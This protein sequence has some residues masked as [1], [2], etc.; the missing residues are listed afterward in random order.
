MSSML[1]RIESLSTILRQDIW[2]SSHHQAKVTYPALPSEH[3]L[4]TASQPPLSEAR[5]SRA[6]FGHTG[7][8]FQGT[9]VP[10]KRQR[11]V[12]AKQ[13]SAR[14]PLPLE[15]R[16]MRLPEDR[17]LLASAEKARPQASGA[18]MPRGLSAAGLA[19]GDRAALGFSAAFPCCDV[20][21]SQV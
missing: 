21:R 20:A 16:G 2:D 15:A 9:L 12:D 11:W 6:D 1:G 10:T 13:D 17:D 8:W 18:S 3:R 4:S 7:T 14:M 19:L 5:R